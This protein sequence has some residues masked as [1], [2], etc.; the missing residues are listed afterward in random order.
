MT[1]VNLIGAE[2]YRELVRNTSGQKVFF[3]IETAPLPDEDLQK[4]YTG[5]AEADLPEDPGSFDASTVKVGTYKN[6]DLIDAK[7]AKAKHA[8][9]LAR[10]A[11]PQE[12][13]EAKD[14]HWKNF[15]SAAP[16]SAAHGRVIAIGYGIAIGDSLNVLLHIDTDDEAVLLDMFWSTVI[17]IRRKEGR[18][19][20]FNGDKFDIPFV[21]RRSWV[22]GIRCPYLMTKYRK[23]EEFSVDVMPHWGMG[24]YQARISLAKLAVALGTAPKN[25]EVEGKY[26]W[27]IV[28]RDRELA[29]RYL[30]GDITSLHGVTKK[31]GLIN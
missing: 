11:Y 16:L 18:L 7:I 28:D 12:L 15:V 4:L 25:D 14:L 19:F 29:E 20:S 8:N 13:A 9:L 1:S 24:D 3:D 31:I 23:M 30:L 5:P 27:M 21:T 17:C 2:E 22:H 26:F 6:Q 10:K